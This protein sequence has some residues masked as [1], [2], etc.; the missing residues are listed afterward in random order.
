MKFHAPARLRFSSR[1]KQ[2]K[3]EMRSKSMG[4]YLAFRSSINRRRK[5]KMSDEPW[6]ARFTVQLDSSTSKEFV[7]D[8]VPEW[9]PLGAK[10]FRDLIEVGYFDKCRIYRVIPGFIIQW[11]ICADPN[12]YKQWGDNKIKDDQRTAA[13]PS[14]LRG[15][16]TL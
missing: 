6:S 4:I 7:V 15:E 9:A 12:M 2:A 14:N 16:S 1:P 13:T 8:V 11:G 3:M 10:R 5:D